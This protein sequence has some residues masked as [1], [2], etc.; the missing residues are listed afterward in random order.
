M[1]LNPN[2]LRERIPSSAFCFRGY[3][4]TN[5]GRSRELLN[6]HAYGAVVSEH[7]QRL[8]ELCS[9]SL[10]KRVS[11][12]ERVQQ[13]VE[14]SVDDFG[15]AIGVIVAM[16][17]AQ[18]RLLD[19]FFGIQWNKCELTF[20]YSLGEVAA[21]IATDVFQLEHILPPP[22]VM[23]G[24]CAALAHDAT[25]GVLFS[26]GPELD[27][28]LV[29]GLCLKVNN[30]GR[31]VI[32]ISSFLSPNTVL[33][34]GQHGTV[35]RFRELM[36]G[37]FPRQ[38]H[39]RKNKEKWPPLHTP[40]LW[41]KNIPNRAAVMMHTMP[42]GFVKPS[43]TI[44]SCV[45]GKANYTEYNSREILN[46]WIDHPQRLWD[47][48]CATLASGVQSVIHV[49]P[50]PN[51]VPATFQRLS[52]NVTSQLSGKGWNSFGKRAIAGFARR[53]WLT[54]MMSQRAALLRAPFVEHILLEDWLLEQDVP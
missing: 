2:Q 40:L 17:L 50:E 41:E 28:D 20:G 22:L 29:T 6:H 18:L 23:A 34:L 8:S 14:T 33:L 9:E 51:L 11:L 31:G 42:G 39:L 5:L 7:L 25:M 52:D 16:E 45:T 15:E 49:G 36:E 19:Q 38:V 3:N 27:L 1:A 24:E 44:I 13:N 43:P 54:K 46:R 32:G 4:T 30:E 47:V 10:G 12:I 21:L 37:N 48:M 26:R 53:P 35:D